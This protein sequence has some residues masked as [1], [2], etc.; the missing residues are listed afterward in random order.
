M[1]LTTTSLFVSSNTD[2]EIIINLDHVA[3]ISTADRLNAASSTTTYEIVFGMSNG[4]EIRFTYTDESN[5]AIA[6]ATI[7]ALA[8]DILPH[9]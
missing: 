1:A 7:R 3:T 4:K 9:A 2:E 5:R 8:Q 6:Y